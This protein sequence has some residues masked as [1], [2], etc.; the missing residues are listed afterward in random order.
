MNHKWK[1]S[2]TV[3]LLIA[4][5]LSLPCATAFASNE[6][7]GGEGTEASGGYVYVDVEA[8][9][10]LTV[11]LNANQAF[12]T[13]AD[14]MQKAGVQVDVYLL[15]EAKKL[16]GYDTYE[17]V[18]DETKYGDL[19]TDFENTMKAENPDFYALAEKFAAKILDTSG[20][21]PTPTASK[22]QES[23]GSETIVL[24][25]LKSGMYLV[26]PRGSDLAWPDYVKDPPVDDSDRLLT[27]A[28][29]DKY[30]YR[31]LPQLISLPSKDEAYEDGGTTYWVS[32]AEEN[33]D[34]PGYHTGYGYGNWT[35]ELTIT[36]KTDR[37]DRFGQLIVKKT[38]DQYDATYGQSVLFS[39]HVVAVKDGETVY[40]DYV[41]IS[42]DDSMSYP[43]TKRVL[44]D[45][46][47]VGAVATVTEEPLPA[48]YY[49]IGGMEKESDPVIF[50][51]L[52]NGGS[53]DD[54]VSVSFENDYQPYDINQHGIVNNYKFVEGEWQHKPLDDNT[55]TEEATSK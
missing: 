33:F 42:F 32:D 11:N 41:S 49:A 30:E 16:D 50:V 10:T 55:G 14:D 1:R 23:E 8:N 35:N 47:R 51:D 46:I 24:E 18:L 21:E 34:F 15:A 9:N 26:V 43:A 40:D 31:F 39:Y 44:I 53:E 36:L 17:L 5:V 20:S 27:I 25:G 7:E 19:K 6:G 22:S 28:N 45:R 12:D 29:S 2:L 54:I 3:L 13:E 4:L 38:L 37:V 52:E 48:K